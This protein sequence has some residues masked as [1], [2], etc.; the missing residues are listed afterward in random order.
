MQMSTIS[1][2]FACTLLMENQRIIC[3]DCTHAQLCPTDSSL[4]THSSLKTVCA[5]SASLL[6]SSLPSSSALHVP[7]TED[8]CNRCHHRHRTHTHTRHQQRCTHHAPA[9][10]CTCGHQKLWKG[11]HLQS[12]E[13]CFCHRS[14]PSSPQSPSHTRTSLVQATLRTH[15][16]LLVHTLHLLLL[17]LLVQRDQGNLCLHTLPLTDSFSLH[18][19]VD[20]STDRHVRCM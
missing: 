8:P 6:S 17:T 4:F 3:T 19:S 18:F 20:D 5:R 10:V 9:P 14:V 15:V 1:I 7:N 16:V 13:H 11:R 2:T 12:N